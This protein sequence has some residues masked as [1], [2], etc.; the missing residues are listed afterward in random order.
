MNGQ[1]EDIAIIISLLSLRPLHMMLR[2]SSAVMDIL[3]RWAFAD[4]I[5]P[6]KW[7]ILPV[8]AY[9]GKEKLG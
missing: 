8:L 4:Q 5:Y 7:Q 9:E 2:R 3:S 1:A 6:T